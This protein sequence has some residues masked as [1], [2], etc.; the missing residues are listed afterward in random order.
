V[1]INQNQCLSIKNYIKI[2]TYYKYCMR[3]WKILIVLLSMPFVMVPSGYA[4]SIETMGGGIYHKFHMK[5]T[6]IR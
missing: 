6:S 3:V 4:D 1:G 2:L 5:N